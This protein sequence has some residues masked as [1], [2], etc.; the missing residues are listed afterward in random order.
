MKT[1]VNI[2]RFVTGIIFIISGFV[3][4]VDPLGFSYKLEEY[5]SESVLDMPFFMP[6][7]LIVSILVVVFELVVGVFLILGIMK[8]FTLWSIF[9]MVVFFAFLTFYSAY[10]DKVTDCGCFGDAIK[11]TPWQ[12]FSKDMV[13]MFFSVILL[14][15][16]KYITRLFPNNIS[17]IVS[18]ISVLGSFFIAYYVLV[19]LPIIDFRPYKIGS[20]LKK[21]MQI[22]ENAPKDIYKNTWIYRVNGVEKE[23]KNKDKPWDIED[24]EYV[25]R[26]TILV[27]KGFVPPIHDFSI[28]DELGDDLTD[29]ILKKD[30]IYLLIS[31]DFR[32]IDKDGFDK[33]KLFLEGREAI[34]MS[35]NFNQEEVEET[36]NLP[37]YTTDA[38]T[39][40]TMIRSNPGLILLEKGIV[41]NKWSPDSL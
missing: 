29:E 27:K 34:V 8:K 2:I 4:L 24:A 1:L 22:P 15:G 12:S 3:K 6:Y 28:E 14:F 33:I 26:K 17:N 5:F 30:K 19:Y 36:Q 41:K 21:S 11:F 37:F 32:K 10:F 31:H 23:F 7:A 25:D 35:S 20:D 16:Q 18:I 9:G 40:K 39:L 38:T 13:L